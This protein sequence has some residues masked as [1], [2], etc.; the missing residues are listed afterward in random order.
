MDLVRVACRHVVTHVARFAAL[1]IG[2]LV[3][4]GPALA[5][6]AVDPA[7]DPYASGVVTVVT[8]P[9]ALSRAA[10]VDPDYVAALR[11]VGDAE[12]VRRW[13]WSAFLLPVVDFR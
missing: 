3:A 1:G 13:A 10:G 11:R 9:D 7:A 5:Q 8:L 2:A 4:A 12:W 6:E